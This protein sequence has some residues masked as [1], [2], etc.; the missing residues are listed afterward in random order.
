MKPVAIIFLALVF[1]QA[2]AQTANQE[3]DQ[4]VWLPFTKSL[5]EKNVEVFMN[6]HAEDVIR[7]EQDTKK[8][9][10]HQQYKES[11]LIDWPKWQ[12]Y[13]TKLN[14]KHT[15]ELR[16]TNRIENEN[17]ALHIGYYANHYTLPN[18]EKKSSFGMFH[19]VLRKYKGVWKIQM[20]TD[21]TLNGNIKEEE[22][23]KASPIG[24]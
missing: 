1:S 9:L 19:V 21:T 2:S 17:S 16:F 10:T 4:Q 13:I 20:D 3:I 7:V 22:F 15:F 14:A 18:G 12:E 24:Y 23:L 5:I 11:M 8:I 6:L